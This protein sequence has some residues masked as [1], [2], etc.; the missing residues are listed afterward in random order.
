MK[1]A[2]Y[3]GSTTG[4]TERVAKQI[5]N[6]LAGKGNVD[7]YDVADLNDAQAMLDYDLLLW[8]ASTWDDGQLQYD[9]EDFVERMGEIDLTNKTVAIFGLGDQH[10]YAEEFVDAIKILHDKAEALGANLTGYWPDDGYDYKASQAVTAGR[11]YGLAIDEDN[12]PHLTSQRV[13]QWC[14]QL[15]Q[16]FCV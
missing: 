3:Y 11:F 2:I 7:L 16:E 1:I 10:G 14:Q 5:Q 12:Q 4:N 15:R 6:E 13:T 8:G 9:W